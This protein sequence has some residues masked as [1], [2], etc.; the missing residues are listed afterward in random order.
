MD[1]KR[2]TKINIRNIR[3]GGLALRIVRANRQSETL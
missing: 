2:E 3:G 1:P